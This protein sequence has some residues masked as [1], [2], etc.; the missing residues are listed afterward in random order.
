MWRS[1]EKNS[2]DSHDRVKR[3]LGD[4]TVAED[5]QETTDETKVL[6]QAAIALLL[7]DHKMH[8]NQSIT[9]QLINQSPINH[10]IDQAVN[11]PVDKSYDQSASL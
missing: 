7:T 9:N 3:R 5:G 6:H 8:A 10:L 1:G 2:E 11:G 4:G